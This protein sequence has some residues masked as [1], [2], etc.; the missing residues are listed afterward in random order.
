MQG[1]GKTTQSL[2]IKDLLNYIIISIGEMI[3]KV[4]DDATELGVLYKGL[5]TIN[6]SGNYYA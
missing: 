3:R 1:A 4:I 2:F 6:I 5:I